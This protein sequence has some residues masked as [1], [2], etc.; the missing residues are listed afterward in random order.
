M[1]EIQDVTGT[2]FIVAEYRAQGNAEQNPLY[3]DPV[4][5]LFLSERTRQAADRIAEGFPPAGQGVR[6]RTRYFDDRLDEQLNHGCR[7][8]VIPGAGL[9]TRGV[10]KQATGVTYFEIDD[11]AS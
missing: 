5:P 8:V 3:S 2:A 6:L 1:T 4:V 10:R 9:D 7:Q 11:A